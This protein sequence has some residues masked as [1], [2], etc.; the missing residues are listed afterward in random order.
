MSW[1]RRAVRA[2]RRA[3]DLLQL[4]NTAENQRV[5]LEAEPERLVEGAAPLRIGDP[6]HRG[7]LDARA[8]GERPS[9]GDPGA[10]SLLVQLESAR[11]CLGGPLLVAGK[12]KHFAEAR[13]GPRTEHPVPCFV[14]QP[15]A[16]RAAL[17]PPAHLGARPGARSQFASRSAKRDRQPCSVSANLDVQLGA[18]QHGRAS[19]GLSL[20]GAHGQAT[21]RHGT[22]AFSSMRWLA[23]IRW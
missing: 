14:S 1:P 3:L 13:P 16:S 10:I 22:S 12:D 15:D 18:G 6:H 11:E 21:S 7:R 23:Q 17:R 5:P 19:L 4:G 9:P 20:E 8:G 2:P